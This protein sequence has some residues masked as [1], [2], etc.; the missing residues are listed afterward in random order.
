MVSLFINHKI[1][2]NSNKIQFIY[3]GL[4]GQPPPLLKPS[5]GQGQR[6]PPL[7]NQNVGRVGQSASPLQ[8]PPPL[9]KPA[10][11]PPMQQQVQL[12]HFMNNVLFCEQYL[13]TALFLSK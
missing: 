2:L 8:G 1:Q 5:G 3:L 11:R 4:H 6:P 9:I 12:D 7:Q 13:L 10:G